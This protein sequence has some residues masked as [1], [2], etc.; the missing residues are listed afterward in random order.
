M[1][2]R[3]LETRPSS[4]GF[5]PL[6]F[7]MI[8]YHAKDGALATAE[9]LPAPSLPVEERTLTESERQRKRAMLACF[10]TQREVLGHFSATVERFR[11]APRYDFRRPPHEGALHFESLSWPLSGER[12]RKLA[13]Q[14]LA[15]LEIPDDRRP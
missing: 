6:V 15:E 7:E 11:P 8:S 13:A 4:G 2:E 3:G 9:F 10:A 1:G 14:A 5:V 12:W